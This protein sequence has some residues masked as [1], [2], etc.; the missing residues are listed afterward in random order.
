MLYAALAGATIPLG[1][2]LARIEHIRPAWLRNEFRHSVIAFGGGVLIAAIALVLV[3][4]GTK[5]LSVIPILLAFGSG[6]LAF[7]LIDRAMAKR[8][9]SVAQLMAMVL[10]FV[11]ESLALGAVLAADEAT[12]LLLASLIALQNLP[13]GFNSYREIKSNSQMSGRTILLGFCALT[14][15]GP[16]S[17]WI[18]VTFMQSAQQTL[19]FIMLFASGGILYLT[20]EDIAPQAKLEYH[21][22]P[23]L[24]AVA[25]F[26]LGLL[27][28]ALV[29]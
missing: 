23:P 4:E 27:G 13:E 9:G 18:G 5:R 28:H 24:G 6:G 12:G 15:L 21:W 29:H 25:G 19:G 2:S 16:L 14:L 10:D 20:F 22:G 17:A 3:P 7:F 1:A 26:M 11:P 8:G